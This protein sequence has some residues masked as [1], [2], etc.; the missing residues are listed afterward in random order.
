[1]I[2]IWE[3]PDGSDLPAPE[4]RHFA[5]KASVNIMYGCDNFCS[6]CIVPYV[7]GRERSRRLADILGEVKRL[8]GDGA[9]ETPDGRDA[10]GAAPDAATASAV[11]VA[12]VDAAVD[13]AET[14]A[15]TATE[16]AAA[17]EE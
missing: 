12:A 3:G 15:E 10:A 4:H 13:A 14:T 1:V 7:R 6:Y 16:T 2:D 17:T 11:T 9:A 5:K 8:A